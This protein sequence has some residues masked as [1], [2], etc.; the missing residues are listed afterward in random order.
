MKLGTVSR[1]T[2]QHKACGARFSVLVTYCWEPG[3]RSAAGELLPQNFWRAEDGR[4]FELGNGTLR[5]ACSCG[6]AREASSVRGIFNPGK[7]CSSKCQAATGHDCECSCAGK[8]HG[9]AFA[10]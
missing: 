5:Y 10:A 1:F 6:A 7:K 4:T 2:A 8:N 3:R 9:A